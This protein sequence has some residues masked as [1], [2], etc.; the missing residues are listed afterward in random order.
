VESLNLSWQFSCGEWASVGQRAEG[1]TFNV[2]LFFPF[3]EVSQTSQL[4][5][6]LH[7]LDDLEHGDEVN[8][9]TGQHLFHELDEGSSEFLLAL[10]PR[11]G[12]VETEG[13][14]VGVEVAVEVVLQHL[15]ELVTGGNV[16]T[17][18]DDGTTG[19]RFIEVRVVTA[20]QF[21]DDHLPDG[22]TTT[23]T[24]TTVSAAL[25]G[26]T[27]VESVRPDGHAAQRCRHRGVV[28]EELVGHHFVLLVSTDAEGRSADTDDR[29]IG[30]VGETLDDDT[31]TGHL[32]QPIVIRTIAP[33]G[34]VLVTSDREGG[35]FVTTTV[36]VLHGRVVGVSVRN[37]EGSLRL[38]AVGVLADTT[39][40]VFVKVD[41][42]TVHGPVEGQSD[43]LRNIGGFQT[44]GNAGTVRRAEAIGQHA[45]G[46]VAFGSAVGILV[47][48][49][50]IF[51]GTVSAIGFVITEE[52]SGET[53]SVGTSELTS[54]A[55]WLLGLEQRKFLA[56]KFKLVAVAD[57]GLP[58]AG[59][60]VDIESQT[61]R[62]TDSGQAD[63]ATRASLITAD[64][65]T[66][67]GVCSQAKVFFGAAVLAQLFRRLKRFVFAIILANHT[68][69]VIQSCNEE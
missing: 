1:L 3:L 64:N 8:V 65:V 37:E 66:A 23:G 43:H 19:Q 29:A 26:S 32:S 10:E 20:I 63:G 48:G 12:E 2:A 58:V 15:I 13:S 46:G 16:G 57:F 59:L 69:G 40:K 33:V 62:A 67:V 21:V 52:G 14:A 51:V 27:E 49:A 54:W 38:A 39:E 31:V 61:S 7:P 36:E 30:D 56:G 47:N 41:I 17:G 45:L 50:S 44:A 68:G 4:G 18:I 55:D 22:V 9:I 28:H 11:S 6:V 42:V 35:D 53:L 25:V 34:L 5:G 24:S 60:T